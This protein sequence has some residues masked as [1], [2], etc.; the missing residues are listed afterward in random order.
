MIT[1]NETAPGALARMPLFP[2][3]VPGTTTSG[4]ENLRRQAQKPLGRTCADRH[5]RPHVMSAEMFRGVLIR[6]RKRADRSSIASS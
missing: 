2:A 6:E 5:G 1:A 3:P 4:P